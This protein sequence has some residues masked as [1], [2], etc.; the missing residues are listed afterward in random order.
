MSGREAQQSP[1]RTDKV[2]CRCEQSR[3]SVGWQ[4]L[5]TSFKLREVSSA[6]LLH[7]TKSAA[8]LSVLTLLL[9][10]GRGAGPPRRNFFGRSSLF[11]ATWVSCAGAASTSSV[12][13]S[14]CCRLSCRQRRR[15]SFPANPIKAMAA[16]SCRSH[17]PVKTLEKPS[18][19]LPHA[20][21]AHLNKARRSAS[22][23]LRRAW[24]SWAMYLCIRAVGSEMKDARIRREH[25]G[26]TST[27]SRNRNSDKK[28]A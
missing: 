2:A 24:R 26:N 20:K 19:A 21:K 12:K 6:F 9:R 16:R 7:L 18:A 25:K 28:A 4:N 23:R 14:R 5:N 11:R 22:E 10:K 8:N 1:S 15:R 17:G 27:S 3:A 13:R